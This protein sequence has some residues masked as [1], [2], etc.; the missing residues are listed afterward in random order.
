V[1]AGATR[2]GACSL[3]GISLRTVQ[4]WRDGGLTDRRKGAAKQVAR[5]LSGEETERLYRTAN[6]PR[7]QDMTPGEIVPTLLDEGIYLGSERTLYR[8][9]KARAALA[10]RQESRSP[11][12]RCRPSE[13]TA[14]GPNQVWCWD[15]TWLKTDVAG[16]F[17]FAY[18]IEDVFS[19]RIV[20]WAVHDREDPELAKALF[21][22]LIRDLGVVPRFVHADNGGPMKGISL[23]AFLVRIGAGLKLQPSPGE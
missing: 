12:K 15:I 10:A 19:R 16:I 22:Q 18:V 17:K 21:E 8:I 7:F 11:V 1:L 2:A 6:E 5:K 14:S 9:L 13:L 23:V 4:R 20:G 3:A